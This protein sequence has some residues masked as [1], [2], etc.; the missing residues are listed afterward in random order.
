MR[1]IFKREAS[2]DELRGDRAGKDTGERDELNNSDGRRKPNC[3]S[4]ESVVQNHKVKKESEGLFVSQKCGICVI[5]S[6]LVS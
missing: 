3:Y 2:S 5:R 6:F 1:R 4:W